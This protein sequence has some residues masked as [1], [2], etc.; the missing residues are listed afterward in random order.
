MRLFVI[1]LA[2]AL[3]ALPARAQDE[4]EAEASPA[5]AYRPVVEALIGEVIVPAHAAF[6]AA[7]EA[8]AETMAAL[9]EKPAPDALAAAREGF[10]V[11]V[12]AFGRVELYR[13]GPAREDNRV[14]RLF[15]WPDRRGRGLRQIE[16]V[17]ADE[18]ESAA[19]PDTLK[20][21]SVALQGL[22]ALEFV[23]FG[24]GSDALG[25]GSSFRCRYGASIAATIADVAA[26]LQAEWSGSFAALVADAGPDNPAY[27]SHGEVFQDILQAAAE[28]LEFVSTYKIGAVIGEAVKK[29]YPRRAPLWRSNQTL[30]MIVANLEG[31]RALLTDDVTA[32]LGEDGAAVASAHFEIRQALERIGPLAEDPRPFAEILRDAPSY[33]LLAIARFPIDG[34]RMILAERIPTAL[35]LIAGF[36]ALDGD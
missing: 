14:E 29:S 16:G 3:A 25:D 19:D 7:A 12:E 21:K 11:L 34:A 30:P 13:F 2:A 15:F 36:N 6:T 32:L 5:R 31:V 33:H 24:E 17:I 28:Q 9:C 18:D 26:T 8:E 27:R 35:G 1:A 20:D 10:G 22:P 4:D 23:L